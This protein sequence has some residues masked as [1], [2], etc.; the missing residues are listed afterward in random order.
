MP[1]HTVA[2]TTNGRCGAAP[3]S[4]LRLGSD[5]VLRQHRRRGHK[6]RLPL[7]LHC[8]P[9]FLTL[10]LAYLDFECPM[11]RSYKETDR[12]NARRR[13]Y[14]PQQL[15]RSGLPFQQGLAGRTG[16][17]PTS[18]YGGSSED[19]DGYQKWLGGGTLGRVIALLPK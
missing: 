19:G 11:P 13:L 17:R 18:S 5:V 10:A 12:A 16:G 3:F 4:W 8:D 15:A 9:S 6:T 2:P 1:R 7:Y 14:V